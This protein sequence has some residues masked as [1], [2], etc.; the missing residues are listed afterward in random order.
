MRKYLVL[1]SASHREEGGTF[2]PSRDKGVRDE[3]DAW[4]KKSHLWTMGNG[5]YSLKPFHGDP[6]APLCGNRQDIL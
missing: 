3:G 1:F 5:G 2:S 4:E 6:G